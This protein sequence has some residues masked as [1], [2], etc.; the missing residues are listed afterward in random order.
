M[1]LSDIRREIDRIDGEL[2]P[3][4]C[5]RLNCSEKVAAYKRAHGLPVLNERR[6]QEVLDS[7]A[8]KSDA[9]DPQ[10][11]GYGRANS[12]VYSSIME[13]S[14]G[15][16][17][18]EM[19]AGAALREQLAGAAHSLLPPDKARIVCQGARG[20]YSHEAAKVL[21]P[22]DNDPQFVARWEDVVS[23]VKNGEADYGLLPVENSSAGSVHEVY[24]LIIANRCHI[25]AAVELPVRQCLLT[26]PGAK[27]GDIKKVISH[28]QALAQCRDYIRRHNFEEQNYGNTATAAAFVAQLGD[29]SVAAI[30]SQHA[31]A[32]Y[33][34][35][36][37]QKSIQT[38][39]GN[40]TRFVAISQR[41]CMPENADRITLLFRLPHVTG[42]LYH[43]LARFALEGLNLTKLESRPVQ[44]GTFE[45]AF[46][47]D[48]EGNLQNDGTISLLCALSE[49]LPQFTLLGNYLEIR[50]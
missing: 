49:E 9:L 43:T 6:E 17:H 23:A 10:K 48:F 11:H 1:E 31:A 13:V 44:S 12:L 42:S 46:Y 37:A 19:D 7:V 36:V 28:P 25:A 15:L 16:Q 8:A 30:G 21:F 47:L 38:V 18:R 22:G 39:E 32:V 3:L 5:E 20:A 41:L 45:Y 33:G 27:L 34:L 50:P 35:T 4:L 40:C 26:V 29:P 24:D 2:V 14:R